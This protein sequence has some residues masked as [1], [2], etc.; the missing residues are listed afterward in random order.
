MIFYS[1]IFANIPHSDISLIPFN[2][3][4]ILPKNIKLIDISKKDAFDFRNLQY[5]N[6][7]LK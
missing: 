6:Y 7:D 2:S 1:Q 5:T 4:T 3:N